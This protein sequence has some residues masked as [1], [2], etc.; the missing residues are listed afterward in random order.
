MAGNQTV[1]EQSSLARP[2]EHGFSLVELMVTLAILAVLL[3]FAAPSLVSLIRD[4]RLATHADLLLDS[5]N[6]ARLEAVRQGKNFTVCPAKAPNTATACADAVADWDSGWIIRSAD[7]DVIQRIGA[8]AGITLST[9]ATAV[10][11]RSTL[12]S[13]TAAAS[14][15]LCATGRMQQQVDVFLSGRVSKKLN[16]AIPCP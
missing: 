11:F 5:L 3:G 13:S 4:S 16:S 10:T 7:G 14:L 6:T 8:K 9:A 2:V 15:T 1:S 12:G